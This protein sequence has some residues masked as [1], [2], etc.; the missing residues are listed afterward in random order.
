MNNPGYLRSYDDPQPDDG[1]E[2]A[3]DVVVP[4]DELSRRSFLRL[5]SASMALAGIGA[6]SR[7]PDEQVV[8]FV[9]MP[10]YGTRA[11]RC[12]SRPRS[13]PSGTRGA[14]W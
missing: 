2:F 5:M 10:E 8:P 3:P 12:F 7:R 4:G 9:R 14:C 11:R 1:A 13:G 6:C